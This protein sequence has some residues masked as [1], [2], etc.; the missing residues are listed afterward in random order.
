[1]FG[2]AR[3]TNTPGDS[4]LLC[5]SNFARITQPAISCES[6]THRFLH[7]SFENSHRWESVF[8]AISV[9]PYQITRHVRIAAQHKKWGT[10][11]RIY[12]QLAAE[13]SQRPRSASPKASSTAD[14][15]VSR[16]GDKHLIC[17]FSSAFPRA[18]LANTR[19]AARGPPV[20]WDLL[21]LPP[22]GL[23][24]IF[25]RAPRQ[26]SHG[27]GPKSR[28]RLPTSTNS[29][30]PRLSHVLR[31]PVVL[32]NLLILKAAYAGRFKS[33]S[34]GAHPHLSI[35][36]VNIAATSMAKPFLS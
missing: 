12:R 15:S 1:V 16:P 6:A 7:S 14:S 33:A 22:P 29:T 17:T 13:G 27:I 21:P 35:D 28:I 4:L 36:V 2:T 9:G 34:E 19:I 24:S 20:S 18:N 3:M 30:G 26:S 10:N 11:Y 23:S 25:R 32:N 8:V 31:T 5:S